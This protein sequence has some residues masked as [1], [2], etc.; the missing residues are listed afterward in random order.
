MRVADL[1]AAVATE[2]DDFEIALV[3]PLMVADRVAGHPLVG[4]LIVAGDDADLGALQ[5]SLS[6]LASQAALAIERITLSGEIARRRSEEYFRTLVHNMGDVIL[7]IDDSDDLI[8]YASPSAHTMFGDTQLPGRKVSDLVDPANREL[9]QQLLDLVRVRPEKRSARADWTVLGT[10][11]GRVEVEVSARDLRHDPTV[12]GL[13]VTLRDVTEQR[14]LERELKHRAFHDLLTGLPNRVL[15]TEQVDRAVNRARANASIAGVLF[16]DLDDFKVVND[17]LGHDIGD[18]LLVAVGERLS[19]RLR[20]ED[21]AAR[22]GGDE[23]AVLVEDATEP[24]EIEDLAEQTVQT[25]AEPIVLGGSLLSAPASIGVATT[26]DAASSSDLLRQADLALYEAKGAGKSR[27]RRYQSELH[28]AVVERL[29]MRAALDRALES[30]DFVLQYQPIVRLVDG[31]T[32]GFEALVRWVHPT[33]GIVAPGDVH[34]GGRGHRADRPD[35]RLGAAAFAS[36]RD[37]LV[38]GPPGA[39]GARTCRSTSRPS[40]SASPASSNACATSSR[41]PAC[42]RNGSM[43]EI[44]ES[45]LLRDDEQV[46]SDLIALRES[47]IRVAIDDFGTG[48][49]SLSYLRQ[50][51]IDVVKIDKS[52][53]DTMAAS[54][55]QRDLVEG[56]VRLAHTLGLEVIAE[57]IERPA[58]PGPAGRHRLPVRAGVSVLETDV[59][60]GGAALAAARPRAGLTVHCRC[61]GPRATRRITWPPRPTPNRSPATT[62]SR[63]TIRNGR[64]WSGC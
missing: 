24:A 23:F 17:T 31:V 61:A 14:Q 33:R 52:F 12:A 59:R 19:S 3:N 55:Q 57:G 45:L 35:R 21:T 15:F 49:S 11:G 51:P 36:G 26:V 60:A 1:P 5:G 50:V 63:T 30:G 56:I 58:R 16:I 46:W 32:V 6:V 9:A 8:R 38:P 7:I 37:L 44:T 25:L 47:G 13:V 48:Y 20:P 54:A 34:R 53:I 40:S 27:W 4:T 10:D 18:Q 41:G 2:L 29:A 39:R 62:C 64:T 22:L 43:L 28:T 42:P